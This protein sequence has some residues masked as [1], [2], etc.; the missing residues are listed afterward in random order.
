[1]RISPCAAMQYENVIGVLLDRR[2][3]L[4]HMYT[5]LIEC[6]KRL[7][8]VTNKYNMEPK[9]KGHLMKAPDC[10]FDRF[11]GM[12]FGGFNEVI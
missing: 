10:F 6:V 5:D 9:F 8:R 11:M 4:E 3:T 7:T 1:M 12:F 2:A